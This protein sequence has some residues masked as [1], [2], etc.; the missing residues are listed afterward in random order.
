MQ[1]AW[2]ALLGIAVTGL[3]PL[4]LPPQGGQKCE[5]VVRHDLVNDTWLLD[6]VNPCNAACVAYDEDNNAGV[7]GYACRC[8]GE[9]PD[10]C[11][12]VVYIPDV[13]RRATPGGACFLPSTCG[14][15]GNCVMIYYTVGDTKIWYAHCS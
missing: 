12:H 14:F 15:S 9:G 1:F 7:P 13:A 4:L 10:P 2:T 11:C 6:C 5:G 8:N 3:V